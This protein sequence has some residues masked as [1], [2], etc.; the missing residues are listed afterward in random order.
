MMLQSIIRNNIQKKYAPGKSLGAYFYCF[1]QLE[2]VAGKID[3]I[4]Q[5]PSSRA[6]RS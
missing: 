4:F 1:M 2:A 3:R 6:Q 5:S